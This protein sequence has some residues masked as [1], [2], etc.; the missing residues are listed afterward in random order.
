M[1]LF[2]SYLR[3]APDRAV[4][5]TARVLC[6]RYRLRLEPGWRYDS[7]LH[8]SHVLTRLRDAVWHHYRSN[9]INRPIVVRWYEGLPLGL[10]I[11]N[12]L[13][14]SL[15]VGGSFEPNEFVFIAKTLSPGMVFVDGG[16]N[17]GLYAILA[18][19]YV[20]RSGRVLAV[21]PSSREC[22]R[23]QAN[24][25]LNQLD[26]VLLEQVALGAEPGESYLAVGGIGREV[27]N[28]LLPRRDTSDSAQAS[29]EPVRVETIDSLVS[30]HR[31]ERV[32]VIKLDIEGSEVDALL[33]ANET[34]ARFQPILLIEAEEDRLATLNRTVDDLVALLEQHDYGV[35]VF[36]KETAQLRPAERPDEPDGQHPG[37]IVAAPAGWSPPLL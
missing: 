5:L 11:G 12:D 29:G 24:V 4:R 31:L 7:S 34:I 1:R 30:R 32:D 2:Q 28:A 15:Y 37:D 27:L 22:Q 18:G 33:G 35:W 13:T 16:A 17:D 26:N 23:L 21:E 8:D 19:H 20:G 6:P 14:S 25:A 10:F 9:P 36:D 3:H